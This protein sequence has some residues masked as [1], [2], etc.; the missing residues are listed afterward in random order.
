MNILVVD[1]DTEERRKITD[2]LGEIN[3]TAEI[4]G[5]G[6][7]LMAV[8]YSVSHRVDTLYTVSSMNRL[9]GFELG[10][11]LRGM[12]PEIELY[13]IGD[14]DRGKQDAMRIMADSYIKRPVTT[15]AFRLA[16]AAEW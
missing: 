16:E 3:D 12:H 7:P 9:S 13:F 11:L 15:E 14:D 2:I 1:P 8:K 10:K 5:F 6:D 4:S